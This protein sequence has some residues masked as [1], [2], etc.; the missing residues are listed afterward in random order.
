MPGRYLYDIKKFKLHFPAMYRLV[1]CDSYSFETKLAAVNLCKNRRNLSFRD[2]AIG[3]T[4][5]QSHKKNAGVDFDLAL[6]INL[7]AIDISYNN[8]TIHCGMYFGRFIIIM[9]ECIIKSVPRRRVIQCLRTLKVSR[10]AV[11]LIRVSACVVCSSASNCY[12]LRLAVMCFTT[13]TV[14]AVSTSDVDA[15]TSLARESIPYYKVQEHSI[16][17]LYANA[18]TQL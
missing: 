18:T 12:S 16:N 5:W 13:L 3:T 17:L 11:I 6:R 15:E 10:S 7:N 1:L 8:P 4:I 14:D 2:T 9:R